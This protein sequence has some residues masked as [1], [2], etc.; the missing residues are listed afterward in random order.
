[1]PL[2]PIPG[3]T[4]LRKFQLG[5]ETTFETQVA[6]TRR[7]PW[8]F[9]PDVNPNWT[10][11]TAD[12]GTLTQAIPPYRAALDITGPATGQLFFND[13]PA[14]LA[15]G[16]GP[17]AVTPTGGGTARTWTYAPADT[18]QDS[19][20]TATGEWFDDAT[21]DAFAFTGG[22]IDNFQLAYPQS[23]GPVDLT[24]NWRFGKLATYP[25]T[26]TGGLTVDAAPTPVYAADTTVSINSTAGTIGVNPFIN[27]VYDINVNYQNNLDIKRFINGTNTRFDVQNYGRGERMLEVTFTF[28]KA[29][30]AIAETVN[31]LNANA[32]ERFV[33][34][35]TV[36]V[37]TAQASI[38]YQ[39][40]IRFSGF[41]FTRTNTEINTNTGFQLVCRNRFDPAGLNYP[42]QF[43]AVNT[44]TTVLHA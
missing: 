6:A 14:L 26:P 43:L 28:A 40:R 22:V 33:E 17:A 7:M 38:P 29:T 3:V 10:N 5:P 24:A 16:V 34:I 30:A 42:A 35:N 12:T 1:M 20:D 32:V 44:L 36:S 18:T 23:L 19:F 2:V 9:V 11:T 13:L 15:Y 39:F 31:W 41:W 8:S 25:A 37:A 4:R 21:A 27:Q